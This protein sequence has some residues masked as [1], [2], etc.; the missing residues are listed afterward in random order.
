[1]GDVM[2]QWAT[3]QGDGWHDVTIGDVMGQQVTWQGDG[4]CDKE[5]GDAMGVMGDVM[6]VTQQGDRWRQGEGWLKE[7]LPI[8]KWASQVSH[9]Q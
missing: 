2:G 6:G 4:W 7:N 9:A 8:T 5:T 1:M 3:Q